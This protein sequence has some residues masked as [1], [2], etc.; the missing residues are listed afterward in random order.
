M[1]YSIVSDL[2]EYQT[3]LKRCHTNLLTKYSASEVWDISSNQPKTAYKVTSRNSYVKEVATHFLHT[4]CLK[5]YGCGTYY[6]VLQFPR[7]I[8]IFLFFSLSLSPPS[9]LLLP[10]LSVS[11]TKTQQ[12]L[13]SLSPSLTHCNVIT[14]LVHSNTTRAIYA[15]TAR[16]SLCTISLVVT[17][18]L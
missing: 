3:G 1:L 2:A 9:S 5:M 13:L 15:H 4:M 6:L 10:S 18:L 14:L 8:F 12:L 7:I 16:G 17:V 11:M